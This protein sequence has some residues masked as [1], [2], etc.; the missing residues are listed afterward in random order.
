MNGDILQARFGRMGARMRMGE[1]ANVERS[2]V[3]T[4]DI[5]T[6]TAG[7]FFDIRVRPKAR[8]ELSVIDLRRRDR[9]LL[10]AAQGEGGRHFYLCGHDERHWFVA[11]V[12]ERSSCAQL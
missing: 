9:H 3:L 2:R 10:L 11:A 6:D 8:V 5:A 7:E 4:L 1:L 12:P